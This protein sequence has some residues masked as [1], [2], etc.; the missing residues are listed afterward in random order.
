MAITI[1]GTTFEHIID[2]IFAETEVVHKPEF[3]NNPNP[4]IDDA[5]WDRSALKVTYVIRLTDNE[6]WILDQFLFGHTLVNLT[7]AIY[8]LNNDVWVENIQALWSGNI[9][10]EKPWE[11]EVTLI[12]IPS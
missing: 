9:N 10:W 4:I 11:Y 2:T 12:I 5:V 8:G 6:K 7:D 3:I 1:N